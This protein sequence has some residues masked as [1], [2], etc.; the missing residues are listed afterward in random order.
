MV[1]SLTPTCRNAPPKSPLVNC[2]VCFKKPSVLSLLDKSA[3]ATIRF[4]TFFASQPST[5]AEAARVAMSGL[6]ATSSKFKGG[7]FPEKNRSSFLASSGLAFAHSCWLALR[8]AAAF[9]FCSFTLV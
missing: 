6:C 9:A 8:A 1:N 7:S 5:L 2:L 4:S 3:E